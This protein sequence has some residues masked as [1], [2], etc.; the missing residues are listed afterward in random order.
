MTVLFI[1]TQSLEIII[2]VETTHFQKKILLAIL[3]QTDSEVTW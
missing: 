2:F 1:Y 3:K